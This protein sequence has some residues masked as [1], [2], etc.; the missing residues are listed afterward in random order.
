MRALLRRGEALSLRFGAATG[1]DFFSRR[2]PAIRLPSELSPALAGPA[3]ALLLRALRL[4]WQ[5]GV[6]ELG[7]PL[8]RI[9]ELGAVLTYKFIPPKR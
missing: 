5:D 1:T 2:L 9:R 4:S 3:E 6:L 8:P 7:E